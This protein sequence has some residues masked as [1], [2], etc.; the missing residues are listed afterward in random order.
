M[1]DP[2]S[3]QSLA[4]RRVRKFLRSPYRFFAD[5]ISRR[6]K[7]RF[8]SEDAATKPYE[9]ASVGGL[10]PTFAFHINDWKRPLMAK[11]FP[12]RQFIYIPI[13]VTE[14]VFNQQ[15]RSRIRRTP[16]AEAMVWG[17]NWPAGVG[18][19]DVP[20]TYVE[21]GF[22]RSVNLGADHTPPLSLSVDPYTPYF[23]ARERSR[24]EEILLTHDF[25]A[26]TELMARA[27]ALLS[28]LVSSGLSKYNHSRPVDIEAIYGPKTR[29]RILVLGQVEDDASIVYGCDKPITNNDLVYLAVLENP[30]AQVFY[31]PHPDVLN[32]TRRMQSNPDQVRHIS[33]VLDQDIPLAQSFE[34][35]D[36]VYAITSQGG[37]EALMRGISVT[38][39]GCPFYSGWG[40][41]DDRQANARRG[42]KL[43]V[44]EVFAAAYILYPRYFSPFTKEPVTPEQALDLLFELR[45]LNAVQAPPAGGAATAL[46]ETESRGSEHTVPARAV[47]A[48]TNTLIP[49]FAFHINDWKRPLMAKWFPDRQ[50]I[51]LPIKLTPEVFARQWEPRIL[52]TPRAEVMVWGMN[53]PAGVGRLDVPTAYVEDGF[54]RSVNLGAD[55]TP[56][57]SLSVDPYTPYFNARE[58]S[59]LEEILLTHDF[60]A[61]TELM[62]RAQALL[63]RL[64]SSGLS[65]YNHSRPVDIEAIYGPKTRRR[66]LVLGQVEDDASI[67]YGCDKPITNN[68]LVYLAVLENPDAQVFYKPHPDVLNGTRRMQSNPDQVRHISQVLDQDI[69]LAQSFETID[70]VYAIT[71]QGGFEALMRGISVTTFGCPFYSGW[72]ITDDRQ[73]NARRGRKLG[74]LEVFAA[75][76]ILYP[77]YFSPFTKE[78]VTPEQALDL[79]FELRK[80][81]AVQAPAVGA[82][83]ADASGAVAIV[84]RASET[85][86]ALHG[87]DFGQDQQALAIHLLGEMRRTT[88]LLLRLAN[89]QGGSSPDS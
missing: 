2:V 57:L 33:Q 19:L 34:T 26:D 18:R 47:A 66:I 40:I 46:R 32:G 25:A 51:F 8:G 4:Q 84:G 88:D 85:A 80:L 10:I 20:T 56:P 63:S 78:P 49:T 73:A 21:D 35:I 9:S 39:F 89:R 23:N 83:V 45:K 70:H 31:K 87:M 48:E 65:K 74:V 71:S 61:D 30:D 43:G 54:L 7:N 59:R 12:D 15:W 58:R 3:A 38:T 53:W 42:R 1:N 52:S 16:G 79:L 77:R 14:E 22:L 6:W 82:G 11:W 27:Q 75:A 69:P 44:L 5:P 29:R 24:L 28:R 41:T 13:K 62:A 76:Y 64:V 60:A 67:V 68:D 81:N 17:M 86:I 36:H 72:G 50:F 37:F 55:H